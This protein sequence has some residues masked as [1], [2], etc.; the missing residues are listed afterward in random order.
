MCISQGPSP[1]DP[2]MMLDSIDSP[3]S[4]ETK[5]ITAQSWVQGD[6]R[7]PLVDFIGISR[8]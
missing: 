3:S 5:G 4:E 2:R 1:Y 6:C 8:A 7:N